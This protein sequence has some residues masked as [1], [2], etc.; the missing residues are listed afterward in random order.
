MFSRKITKCNDKSFFLFGPRGTGK[1]TWLKKTL[2][3]AIVFDLLESRFY[4]EFLANPDAIETYISEQYRG[5]V[6]IDEV[7]RI[8]ELLNQVHRM[9]E[10]KRLSF[11]LTGSSARK[12]RKAGVNLL[13]GRA[14]TKQL[15]PLICEELED[16]FSLE[17][18]LLYGHLP[19]VYAEAD[20]TAYLASYVQTY[21]REEVLQEG[22][23]RNLAAF[24]RFLEAASFSQAQIL[25]V[26]E[27]SRE[28]Q[29]ER[30]VVESYFGILEDLL[31]GVRVPAFMKR[32]QR[33]VIPH[34]KFFFFDVGIYRCLRPKGPL[35]RP[36]YIAGNS[37][38]TLVWQ[39]IRAIV[40]YDSLGYDIFHWRDRDGT[41]VDLVLY[42]EAGLVAIEVKHADKIRSEDLKGLRAFREEYPMAR[43]IV[44]YRGKD[45][46]YINNISLIPVELFLVDKSRYLSQPKAPS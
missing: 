33:A 7:Q 46:K 22:L 20:P 13:A 28:C 12:L 18:S 37:L 10:Q 40:N 38:E 44:L 43:C 8:P 34:P 21:L 11:V 32:A 19:M 23:T 39:E 45:I 27:V 3:D 15:F 42:G 1:T 30:K 29:V 5:W 25:N 35:D 26:S 6:V 4:R 9:I 31:L 14:L 36:E 16:S 17:Q 2:P 41:E 24:S